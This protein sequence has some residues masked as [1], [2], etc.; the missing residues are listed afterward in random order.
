MAL[1]TKIL[2]RCPW[3]RAALAWAFIG[4]VTVAQTEQSW[5]QRGTLIRDAEIEAI[6]RG[7]ATP[8]LRASGLNANSVRIHLVRNNNLNAFV[9]GGL[10]IFIYTGLLQRAET[11]NQVTGVL[12]HEI[13]HIEGGHLA[14]TRDELRGASATAI[15]S[16]IL[17]VA[18]AVAA[19]DARIGAAV[20]AGGREAA[21]RNYLQYSRS[22]ES[23]ADQA[24]ARLLDATGQSTIGLVE[25]LEVLG[26]Q[27][28]LPPS[29]Q[30]PYMRTH[31][32]SRDRVSA[33]RNHMN[34]SRYTNVPDSPEALAQHR[35]MQAKL[36]GFLDP[37]SRV[38][39]AYP[40]SDQSLE[41]LYA[42]AV[43][44]HRR[45]DPVSADAE[46]GKLLERYPR[47]AYFHEL[48]G[49]IRF[50]RGDSAGSIAAYAKAVELSRRQPLI[51]MAYAR[52]V[53]E[54]GDPAKVRT[55]IP[56]LERALDA[57][58]DSGGGWRLLG[59]AYGKVGERGEASLALAESEWRF[60]NPDLAALQ[61]HRAQQEFRKGT[62]GW[63]R[64][65]DLKLASER[66]M[67]ARAARQR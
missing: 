42:R 52:A 13:G 49:Q 26:N 59:T 50:E 29:Q 60:G 67:R 27:E 66:L 12:A 9:A 41:A 34:R 5:A 56:M 53:V 4:I 21:L 8:L 61:A 31:P 65:E 14:R 63:L 62:P 17:G 10:Q 35:R 55:V 1:K 19:G 7:Q 33:L 43:A 22:H 37:T 32:F 44:F 6:I 3:L 40:E 58:S 45:G 20:A 16:T 39:A 30:D 23:S 11:P 15:L 54:A 24:A 48:D 28:V 46:L 36:A 38:M 51:V 57:E 47:D 18:A 25:F 2:R 64:A